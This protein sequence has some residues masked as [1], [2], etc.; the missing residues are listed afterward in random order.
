MDTVDLYDCS[1]CHLQWVAGSEPIPGTCPGC[2]LHHSI[3]K[4]DVLVAG[5]DVKVGLVRD[6]GL[7][8]GL[9]DPQ[10]R[11]G[12]DVLRLGDLCPHGFLTAIICR[13]CN[14]VQF[15]ESLAEVLTSA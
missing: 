11:R 2:R 7:R 6:Y 9:L 5:V 13:E 4:G 10:V 15:A 8:D 3:P 1:R 14:R 12:L